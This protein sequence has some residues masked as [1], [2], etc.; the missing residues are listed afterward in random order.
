MT[1]LSLLLKVLEGETE[2][3]I[4]QSRMLFHER[5]L[6]DLGDN[7][8]C[9][10]SLI[11]PDFYQNA[12]MQL[13][14]DEE[15]VR[16]N[17]FDWKTEFLQVFAGDDPGFD[18][19]IGNPP[20]IRV[21]R[22]AERYPSEAAFYKTNYVA[23]SKGNFDIYVLF[24][25]RGLSLL[26]GEGRLGFILPHKFFTA[27]YGEPLR[28]LISQGKHLE[29]VVHFGEQQVFDGATTYTCLMFLAKRAQDACEVIRVSEVAQWVNGGNGSRQMI[30]S[31]DIG[32]SQ[33]TLSGDSS[34]RLWAQL[35]ERHCPLAA[36]AQRIAQGIRTSANEVYVL[37]GSS[38]I[39]ELLRGYSS[40]LARRVV[41]EHS[42]VKGFLRGREIRR[43]KPLISDRVVLWPYH[44]VTGQVE[45]RSGEDL[46]RALPNAWG[47]L[48]ANR[49]YLEG[50][51]G[52]RFRGSRWYGFGR[53]QNIELMS[54]PKILVPDIAERAS[55]TI[56]RAGNW[57]FTSGYGIVLRPSTRESYLYLLGLLNSRV[58]DAFLKSISTALRGG[59]FRYF[60]QYL[61]RVP[62]RT[63]DFSDPRDRGRHDGMVRLVE[64]ML[65]LHEDLESVQTPHDRELIERE[66][67]ATDTAI[68]RLVYELY[69]LTDDEIRVV[70]EPR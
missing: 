27:Q 69:G 58:V 35:E 39:D 46:S 41:V 51:E 30:P 68:D 23:A 48:L 64:R 26:N 21:Q 20:Y 59:F 32:A 37:K 49:N 63:I 54:S 67:A 6:P 1:K 53:V 50:R 5:A 31:G 42:A 15:R 12:Q 17:V 44:M 10:N 14:E 25:E 22:L 3:S 18:T 60:T 9:G 11:G 66:I 45:L 38:G 2:E 28:R 34:A 70:E 36:L 52:G 55:F 47:Y 19:V 56:D 4:G 43:Y 33:W 40:S 65:K 13:L 7:I 24:V 8:K 29:H 61:E 16:I 57:A 62:I